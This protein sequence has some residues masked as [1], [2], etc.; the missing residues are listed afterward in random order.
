MGNGARLAR[1]KNSSSGAA[2]SQ[3]L[4]IQ[5]RRW[6]KTSRQEGGSAAPR[7]NGS[8]QEKQQQKK[9]EQSEEDMIGRSQSC[10]DSREPGGRH[11]CRPGQIARPPEDA[12]QGQKQRQHEWISGHRLVR[13]AAEMTKRQSGYMPERIAHLPPAVR[14][15]RAAVKP[16]HHRTTSCRQQ[17]RLQVEPPKRL[18]F[19]GRPRKLGQP[20]A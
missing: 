12:Q 13:N 7:S 20:P 6:Q 3:A 8:G 1:S 15:A 11:A 5:G 17:R 19:E 2:V 18:V 9:G 4:M 10:E 14:A 16:A